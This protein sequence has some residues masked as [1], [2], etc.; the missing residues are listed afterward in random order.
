MEK[1]F[2]PKE[3]IWYLEVDGEEKIFKCLVTETECITFLGDVE[4][5]HL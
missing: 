1:T 2:E 5:K 4:H 3:H